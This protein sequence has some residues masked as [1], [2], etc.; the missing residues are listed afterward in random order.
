[1]KQVDD[2]LLTMS[3]SLFAVASEPTLRLG[4]S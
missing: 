3:A 2:G 1:M 4:Y